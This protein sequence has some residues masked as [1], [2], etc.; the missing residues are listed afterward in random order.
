MLRDAYCVLRM[1]YCVVRSTETDLKAVHDIAWSVFRR[2]SFIIIRSFS[3][4]NVMI[5][6]L[7]AVHNLD[8]LVG[9]QLVQRFL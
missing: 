1:P 3:R 8:F 2:S 7:S 4:N 5:K 9:I 6:W